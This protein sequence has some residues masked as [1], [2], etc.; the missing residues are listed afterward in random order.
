MGNLVGD[1]IKATANLNCASV[2]AMGPSQNEG[3][4]TLLFLL[5]QA[6]ILIAFIRYIVVKARCLERTK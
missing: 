2:T 1:A 5:I 3:I 6:G 4:I